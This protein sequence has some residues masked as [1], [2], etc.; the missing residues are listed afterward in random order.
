M[1]TYTSAVPWTTRISEADDTPDIVR[2]IERTGNGDGS[3]VDLADVVVDLRSPSTTVVACVGDTI[4]GALIGRVEGDIG[5]IVTIAIDPAWR[6]HGIGFDAIERAE[7]AFLKEGCR[8]PAALLSE[9]EV[10]STALENR[11]FVVTPNSALREGRAAQ[12]DGVL[13]PGTMGG[14]TDCPLSLGVVHGTVDDAK[15]RRATPARS[16]DGGRAGQQVRRRAAVG[17]VAVRATRDR[18]DILCESSG[19]PTWLAVRRTPPVET[20]AHG[21]AMMADELHR[22]FEELLGL[23]HVVVFIDE[24]DDIASLARWPGPRPRRWSTSCSRRWS[25]VRVATRT[26]ARV[27]HQLNRGADL[28]VVRPGLLRPQPHRLPYADVRHASAAQH[29]RFDSGFRS[30]PSNW[31][32]TPAGSHQL[33]SASA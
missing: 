9:G 28:V 30:D 23:D 29:A 7:A 13:D 24:V 17:D 31:S 1:R 2:L 5:R 8:R 33:A 18:Q 25:C 15:D 14:R 32:T 27:C 3:P 10:G 19:G 21:A 4:V 16:A 20:G 11:G 26:A 6:H 22:A 12:A